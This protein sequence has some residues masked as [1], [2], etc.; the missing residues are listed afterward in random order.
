[1]ATIL[2]MNSTELKDDA[3]AQ[4]F[5]RLVGW[6]GNAWEAIFYD[7]DNYPFR[8]EKR[9]QALARLNNEFTDKMQA[10]R[11]KHGLPDFKVSKK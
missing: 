7:E 9:Q 8:S 11:E 3:V 6:H 2:N 1:M 4:E 5:E 10:L